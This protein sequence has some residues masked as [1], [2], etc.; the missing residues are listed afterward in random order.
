[1]FPNI[2]TEQ[3]RRGHSDESVAEKLG[4][5][6]QAYRRC[7][8]SGAFRAEEVVA[9]AEMYEKSMDYLLTVRAG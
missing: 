1:M 7:K 9:L 3:A 8:K 6:G 4:M 5:T 2:E